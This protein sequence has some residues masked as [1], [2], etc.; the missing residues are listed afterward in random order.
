MKS[1]DSAFFDISSLE[2][3][4]QQDSPVHRL[5][6][7][8]KLITSA[9]FILSV[10]SFGKYEI[11]GMLPFFL[12]PVC[13]AASGNIPI[14]YILKKIVLVAPFAFFIGI[15]NPFFDQ[16]I[17]YSIGTVSISGG[18]LS[19]TSILLR[20]LLT[21]SAALI[22][23]A[24]SGFREICLA[25][26]KLHTPRAF[27]IQLLFLYRYI[28]VLISEAGRM[29]RARSL[30]TFHT[31]GMGVTVAGSMIGH[32][33]IRTLN[34]AQRIHM[35]MLCRGFDGEIRLMRTLSFTTTDWLF[36]TCW[37]L[38]FLAMRLYNI[39]EYL[40]LLFTG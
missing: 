14:D 25:L 26:E 9:V 32:L 35:A 36:M 8:A 23:I 30:R 40:G 33:L 21:V 11:S 17:I 39:P 7:R 2:T 3:L 37:S 13:L 5:D 29:I 38:F 15:F 27:A 6:P 1:I 18:W 34:R 31:R 16:K 10:V 28:F 20:F 12:F 24:V 19:F 4:A 22:L